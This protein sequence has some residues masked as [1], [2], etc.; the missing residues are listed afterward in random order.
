MTQRR[1]LNRI[2]NFIT[3]LFDI[4]D[5]AFFLFFFHWLS[6]CTQQMLIMFLSFTELRS[7]LFAF[8]QPFFPVLSKSK[9]LLPYRS[10]KILLSKLKIEAASKL[11]TQINVNKVLEICKKFVK[12]KDLILVRV[13]FNFQI[14][15]A[16]HNLFEL[17]IGKIQLHTTFYLYP[18]NMENFTL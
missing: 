5:I 13:L 15:T 10:L 18:S 12:K 9:T 16:N 7:F 8:L 14:K 17:E 4:F 11:R 6:C 1:L 3:S 2:F